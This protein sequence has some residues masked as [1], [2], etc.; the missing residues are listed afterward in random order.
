MGIHHSF[1][2]IYA[3]HVCLVLAVHI[4][5]LIFSLRIECCHEARIFDGKAHLNITYSL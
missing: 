5:F 2:S 3:E 4:L 1:L